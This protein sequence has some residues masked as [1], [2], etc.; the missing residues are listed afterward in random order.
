[1]NSQS[2]S[3]NYCF[4]SHNFSYIFCAYIYLARLGL[5]LHLFGTYS[6]S[7]FLMWVPKNFEQVPTTLM[8]LKY[9]FFLD[10]S[11]V[12]PFFHTKEPLF[13]KSH[14]SKNWILI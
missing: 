3:K 12:S 10:M 1:M 2:S 4:I 11:A 13:K 9:I 5:C 14:G 8:F 7:S 6:A